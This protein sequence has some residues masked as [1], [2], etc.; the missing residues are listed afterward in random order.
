MTSWLLLF[1]HVLF[2]SART[3]LSLL[4]AFISF[5]TIHLLATE[6]VGAITLSGPL[7]SLT[8]PIREAVQQRYDYAAAL[9]A[10]SFLCLAVK[11]YRKDLRQFFR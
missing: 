2:R 4:G 6:L 9:L 1:A 10:V 3:Q 11:C 5:P 8:G 7:S